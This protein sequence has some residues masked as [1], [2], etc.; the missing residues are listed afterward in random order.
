MTTEHAPIILVKVEQYMIPIH[1]SH[2]QDLILSPRLINDSVFYETV[3]DL[4]MA[5]F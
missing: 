1:W 5:G 4:C 2:I 3:F